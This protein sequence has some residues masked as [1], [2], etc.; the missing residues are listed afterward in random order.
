MPYPP[1]PGN[2]DAADAA[3]DAAQTS[4]LLDTETLPLRAEYGAQLENSP[5]AAQ[6][7]GN[8]VR[9]VFLQKTEDELVFSGNGTQQSQSVAT[10]HEFDWTPAED[11]Q[12]HAFGFEARALAD[13]TAVTGVKVQVID[14]DTSDP[15]FSSPSLDLFNSNTDE[16][17]TFELGSGA[18]RT[19]F[20][21]LIRPEIFEEGI[22][23]RVRLKWTSGTF[24][25]D[26]A[27]GPFRMSVRKTL[28]QAAELATLDD[29][30]SPAGLTQSMAGA[31]AAQ[32]GQI[33]TV[34]AAQDA[35]MA[36]GVDVA[37]KN[38]SNVARIRTTQ[39][40]QWTTT[41]TGLEATGT[42]LTRA[43]N[44]EAAFTSVTSSLG[45]GIQSTVEGF[46]ARLRHRRVNG[47]FQH[48][49]YIPDDLGNSE[50]QVNGIEFV[51]D[52]LFLAGSNSLYEVDEN[53]GTVTRVSD[54]A[55]YGSTVTFVEDLAYHNG[56]LYA[57]GTD[58]LDGPEALFVIDPDTSVATEV[59]GSTTILSGMVPHSITSYKGELYMAETINLY[60]IDLINNELILVGAM[61]PM[62]TSRA[63]VGT[64]DRLIAVFSS[65]FREVNVEDA[66]TSTF[67]SITVPDE[68][69]DG[70]TYKDGVLY[71]VGHSD[72][73]NSPTR[74]Y[75][76]YLDN[77]A[78]FPSEEVFNTNSA[79]GRTLVPEDGV[80]YVPLD[81]S[82][83]I[84]RGLSYRVDAEWGDGTLNHDGN[85]FDLTVRELVDGPHDL[86]TSKELSEVEEKLELVEEH[87]RTIRAQ[88][89]TL[90]FEI[91]EGTIASRFVIYN[92]STGGTQNQG[93][94]ATIRGA[95]VVSGESGSP[96][97]FGTSYNS[98]AN[99]LHTNGAS[100]ASGLTS[101]GG[102]TASNVRLV[103]SLNPSDAA[104]GEIT[105]YGDRNSK[106][107]VN[108]RGNMSY[109]TGFGQQHNTS[110]T[111]T[112]NDR[113]G[114]THFQI[115]S[116]ANFSD[117]IIVQYRLKER[118]P[119][120]D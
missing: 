1:L 44:V 19:I 119:E 35:V 14:P 116:L 77:S 30:V 73:N 22:T 64:P 71:S 99:I 70:T 49:A 85:Q 87:V 84:V 54:A 117:G 109:E 28:G 45:F 29:V 55:R 46:K 31:T 110:V 5:L 63:I 100:S 91:P 52:R 97:N 34:N 37:E 103:S 120:Y 74:V 76:S 95:E 12:V 75:A 88:G 47:E 18:I 92:L 9:S 98:S 20:V 113:I 67:T 43:A 11:T 8:D 32:P 69:V 7:N 104:S 25:R 33:L 59:E 15:V 2:A 21:P 23:Y 24:Y 106:F 72:F 41:D 86:I 13:T 42:T 101:V 40:R 58:G 53:E 94:W 61:D 6:D 105:I 26:G 108:G 79:A 38:G 78:Y 112:S 80:G 82:F 90:T 111:F 65:S 115:N 89:S 62:T 4:Q 114:A 118:T 68:H 66:T 3:E 10:V 17:L 16:Q 51:G 81:T 48:I 57:I 96:E 83:R 93:I 50:T 36:S 102:Y 56:Q 27:N 107:K 39:D 60:K